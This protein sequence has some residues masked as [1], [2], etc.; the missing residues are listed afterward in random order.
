MVDFQWQLFHTDGQ[1]VVTV[2]Q[3]DAHSEVCAQDRALRQTAC[4][5]R[6]VRGNVTAGKDGQGGQHRRQV[7]FTICETIKSHRWN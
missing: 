1:H 6:T 5:T 2:I 7:L 3:M 4:H